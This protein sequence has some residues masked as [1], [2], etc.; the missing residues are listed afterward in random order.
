MPDIGPGSRPQGDEPRRAIA[1]ACAAMLL[2]ATQEAVAKWLAAEYSIL[3]LMFVRSVV[4]LVPCAIIVRLSGGVAV[5]RTDRLAVILGRA[6]LGFLAWAS[7]YFALARLPLAEV[8]TLSFAAPLFTTVLAILLL[9]EAVT[10]ARFALTGLGFV[11]VV[12]VASP[13]GAAFEPA[14]AA[15]VASALF[16]ALAVIAI[17]ALTRTV[18]SA[19]LL[20]Y[21]TL[22]HMVLSGALQP[23][24]WITPSA[25]DLALMASIGLTSGC[26][27]YLLIQ[28]YRYA[29][30]SVVAPFDYTQLV[31]ATLYG[32]LIFADLP[33]TAT[34][35]GA[36]VI[37]TSGIWLFRSEA[38]AQ[39]T[40]RPSA[41]T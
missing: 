10:V 39:G 12:I 3:Q 29:P 22:L 9:G 14:A 4:A 34:V 36:A 38:R 8:T 1:M 35:I 7:Y 40:A 23:L 21:G 24:V 6:L 17:R 16:Y 5:L 18:S 28:A 27:Q 13:G 25:F 31:W 37:I 33:A 26:A 19:T 11:G 20:V 32:W 41:A 30:A 15:A 2:F